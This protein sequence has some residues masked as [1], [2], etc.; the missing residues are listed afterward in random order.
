MHNPFNCPEIGHGNKNC[1]WPPKC[2]GKTSDLS[3]AAARPASHIVHRP[4]IDSCVETWATWMVSHPP[5][6]KDE[7]KF[8]QSLTN[9]PIRYLYSN[10]FGRSALVC[11]VKTLWF[12]SCAACLTCL[13]FEQW[14][15]VEAASVREKVCGQFFRWISCSWPS[16]CKKIDIGH[17]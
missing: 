14:H 6:Q 10:N 8:G 16:F 1:P 17:N 3:P 5:T 13:G 12:Q 7:G 15:H 4:K 9:V 2:I 11:E